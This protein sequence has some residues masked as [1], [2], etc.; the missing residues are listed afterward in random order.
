MASHPHVDGVVD[1][2]G[3]QPSREQQQLKGH[4]VHRD[5]YRLCGQM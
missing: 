2:G 4:E 3:P 1:V 5:D